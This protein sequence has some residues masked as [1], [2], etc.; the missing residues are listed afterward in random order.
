MTMVEKRAGGQRIVSL[1]TP[2][3]VPLRLSLA[4]MGDRLAALFIDLLVGHV[5]VI[6][7]LLVLVFALS[8]I[9]ST[10]G[11]FSIVILFLFFIRAPYYIFFELLWQGQTPG[12]RAL[13]LQ[14]VDRK[15]GELKANAVVARNLMREIEVFIPLS[16]FLMITFGD[17]TDPQYWLYLGWICVVILIPF[18]NSYRMR[19]G[20]LIAGTIVLYRPRPVLDQELAD[21]KRAFAFS[22]RHLE[23][24]GAYELQ[25]LEDILRRAS[26]PD[27]RKTRED[28]TRRI[29]RKIGYETRISTA[30]TDNF[31]EDFYAAQRAHLEQKQLL[32]DKRAD[33]HYRAQNDKEDNGD[34]SGK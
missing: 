18:F 14:V 23:A 31:L 33:K 32:G 13:K 8:D 25:V 29:V 12:K 16:I 9:G 6:V 5:T 20:D 7:V 34:G 11:L 19:A 15:G 2:E 4:G 22:T 26:R 3:G 27:R 21:G 10:D 1:L 24:Y 30:E 28:V 17:S